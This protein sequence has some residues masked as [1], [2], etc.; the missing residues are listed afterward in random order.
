M[1][2]V[3]LVLLQAGNCSK[4]CDS[5]VYDDYSVKTE[6]YFIPE[7]DQESTVFQYLPGESDLFVMGSSYSRS[8]GYNWAHTIIKYD[9]ASDKAYEVNF[10]IKVSY[11]TPFLTADESS[12]LFIGQD[13][14]AKIFEFNTVTQNIDSVHSLQYVIKEDYVLLG[15]TCVMQQSC[16]MKPSISMTEAY[17]ASTNPGGTNKLCRFT[18]GDTLIDCFEMDTD[19]LV[20]SMA[21]LSDTE[22]YLVMAG[23]EST[24]YID[25]YRI[26]FDNAEYDWSVRTSFTYSDPVDT[27]DFSI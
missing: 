4:Q 20:H 25:D 12:I 19:A 10:D 7:F 24:N 6:S 5:E 23:H 2:L 27:Y 3:T 13:S 22:V 1:Y 14:Y 17:I 16:V 11:N 21:V 9:S 15:M 26:D 8:S 18:I